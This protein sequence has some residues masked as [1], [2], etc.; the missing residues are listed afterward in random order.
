MPN[1]DL[2]HERTDEK[3]KRLERRIARVYR[4]AWDDLEKTVID[5]FTAFESGTKK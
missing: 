3:L 1:R 5:Y 2:G 4:E